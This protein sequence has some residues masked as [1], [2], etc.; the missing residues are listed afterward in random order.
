MTNTLSPKSRR[1]FLIMV[2]LLLSGVAGLSARVSA[3]EAGIVVS[4]ARIR[5]LPGELPLAGYMTLENRGERGRHLV[6]ASSEWFGRI[7]MHRS[8]EESDQSHMV[9]SKRVGIDPAATVHFAPGGYHLMLMKRQWPIKVGASVPVTLQFDDGEP[10]TVNFQVV[11]A[12]A[13]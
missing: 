5:W 9:M 6:G 13:P 7:M 8:V 11:G 10:L 3:D 1:H 2:A 12:A 4:D